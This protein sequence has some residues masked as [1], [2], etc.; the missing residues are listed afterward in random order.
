M[1][2]FFSVMGFGL[3]LV[4][5]CTKES[6][7]Q[8]IPPNLTENLWTLDTI[9]INPPL[10]YEDL[11]EDQ[12]FSYNSA[13]A[14]SQHKAQ[15]TFKNDGSV[16]C[17]GDWDFGYTQWELIDN[18]KN[19]KVKQGTGLDTLVNWQASGMQ[20]SYTHR[21]SDGAFYGTFIYK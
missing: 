2:S 18:D 6:G 17:S 1:K 7:M 12:K 15:M 21:I 20:F 13:L 4:I 10:K 9:L 11:T 5:A 8:V 16:I 19:I 14:W 3:L